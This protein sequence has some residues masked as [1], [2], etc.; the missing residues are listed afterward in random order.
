VDRERQPICEALAIER[1][2]AFDRRFESVPAR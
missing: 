1:R 2:E